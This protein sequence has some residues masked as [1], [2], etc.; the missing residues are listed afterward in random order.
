MTELPAVL[1]DSLEAELGVAIRGA[2]RVGGGCIANASR[3]ETSDGALF[4]KWNDGPAGETFLAEAEGL[5]VLGS[6]GSPMRIPDV[7]A[8]APPDDSCPGYLVL[9]FIEEGAKIDAFWTDL[10]AGLAEMHRFEGP[11]YGFDADNFIGRLPQVNLPSRSW[12][13]FFLKRRIDEQVSMARSR[14]R[15][16]AAW[17]APLRRIR[18]RIDDILPE[19]PPRSMLHGDLWHGNVMADNLSKPVLIDPAA[20]FGHRETDLAMAE[21]FGGFPQ[22]F[23]DAYRRAWPLEAGYDERRSLYQLYHLINHLNMFGDGYAGGVDRLLKGWA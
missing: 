15:W 4:L 19:A 6:A 23:F 5:R 16:R 7:L 14:G 9:E 13:E 21:L 3:I 8:V 10:G 2:V 12:P 22:A 18:A 11:A 20:Y 17:D 1:R